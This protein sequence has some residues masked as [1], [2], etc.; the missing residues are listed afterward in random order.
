[1]PGTDVGEVGFAS[2]VEVHQALSMHSD[3]R[4][5][6]VSS[7]LVGVIWFDA[8]LGIIEVHGWLV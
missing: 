8:L 1:M 2:M 5:I 6:M 4:Y 7:L 3:F